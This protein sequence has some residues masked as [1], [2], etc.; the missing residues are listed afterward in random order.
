MFDDDF[1]DEIGDWE[2]THSRDERRIQNDVLAYYVDNLKLK[3]KVKLTCRY[4][5]D[6]FEWFKAKGTG[7]QTMMNA[8]LKA[9]MQTEINTWEEGSWLDGLSPAMK[10]LMNI[11]YSDLSIKK[12][13]C[14]KV[15]ITGRYDADVIRW[16]KTRG[17][18]YQVLMNKALRV[19]MEASI[20][21]EMGKD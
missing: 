17:K 18:N 6:M 10:N 13:I 8:A 20:Q 14:E 2:E 3:N 9:V 1:D 4:D 21:A 19:V 15:S 5:R 7:Y 16:F 12:P 11:S